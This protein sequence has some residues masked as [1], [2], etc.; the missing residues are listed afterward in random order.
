MDFSFWYWLKSG[1]KKF[2][3]GWLIG[4]LWA[5][6]SKNS[7]TRTFILYRFTMTLYRMILY[8]NILPNILNT[9]KYTA[10][11]QNYELVIKSW[12]VI[13]VF[14]RR[15]NFG[16]ACYC[17]CCMHVTSSLSIIPSN[18]TNNIFAIFIII[19]PMWRCLWH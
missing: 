16:K 7:K 11:R 5:I 8:Y 18:I 2:K 14:P 6:Q 1:C 17:L 3:F 10:Y 4:C 12:L 19:I 15:R 9:L 13:Y